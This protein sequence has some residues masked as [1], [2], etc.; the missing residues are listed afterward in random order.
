V[1]PVLLT[2]L[3]VPKLAALANGEVG[4]RRE[5]GRVQFV[6][7][8]LVFFRV[9]VATAITYSPLHLLDTGLYP[10]RLILSNRPPKQLVVPACVRLSH[11]STPCHSGD[12]RLLAYICLALL[13]TAAEPGR[14]SALCSRRSARERR[15]PH[16]SLTSALIGGLAPIREPEATR[17]RNGKPLFYFY[18][19]PNTWLTT[20]NGPLCQQ[21]QVCCA[22]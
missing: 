8:N 7:L 9:L 1:V 13:P 11:D 14:A 4:L 15:F 5:L 22:V 12:M 16:T 17:E 18:D 3:R 19:K 2:H 20:R 21:R 10:G 6:P